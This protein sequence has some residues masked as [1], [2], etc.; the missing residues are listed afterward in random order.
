M[1]NRKKPRRQRHPT[2]EDRVLHRVSRNFEFSL[3]HLGDRGVRC[4]VSNRWLAFPEKGWGKED[5]LLVHVMTLDGDDDPK[6][7][8]ELVLPRAELE[9]ALRTV[10]P[11]DARR[12]RGGR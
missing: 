11:P 5:L 12:P 8:C 1:T 3:T 4:Y 2:P 7:L 6:R 10:K 9:R